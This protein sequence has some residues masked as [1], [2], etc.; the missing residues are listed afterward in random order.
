M[1]GATVQTR[2]TADT[3]DFDTKTKS[4]SSKISSIASSVAKGIGVATAA[5]TAAV[6]KMVSDSVKAFA[7]YEQLIGGTYTLFGTGAAKSLEEYANQ[8][9]KTVDEVKSEYEDLSAAEEIVAVNAW[10]AYKSAGLSANEYLDQVNGFAIGFKTYL[11]GSSKA[12]AELA[13]RVVTA[14]ADIVA[15]TGRSQ[16]SI[17]NAFNGIM[18]GNYMMLDNL[19]MG[20]KPTKEGMQEVIDKVN[21]WNAEQG[22]ATDYQMGNLA[23]MEAALVDYVEMQGLA[24]YAAKEASGTIQ[25]ALK[26]TQASYKNLITTL[27]TGEGLEESINNFFESLSALTTQVLPIIETVLINIANALPGLVDKINEML[28]SLLEGVLPSLIQAVVSLVNGLIKALPSLIKT[29]L[30]PLIEGLLSITTAIIEMLP[31]I[32]IMIAEMLPSLMPQIIDAILSIIPLLIDNL[33]LFLSAGAQL[34]GGLIAGIINSIPIL[35][36]RIGEIVV[37]MIKSFKDIDLK[38]IGKDILKGLWNGLSSMKDWVVDKVKS[39]GKSILKG[40]KGILGIHSPS[41]EFAII[42]RYSILGYTE[43]LDDMQ[44]DV[45]KQVAETFSISPQLSASSGMHF[46]P[47]IINNNYVDIQ[48]DPLGQMVNS[49]KTYSGGAKNDFNYGAGL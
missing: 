30:P 38:Q 48:Q 20:I 17:Q 18:K 36:A 42:G 46:S 45:Q 24:G 35:L 13:D 40:L 49:I 26:M 32:I 6:G 3:K 37:K 21:E 31:D 12:A 5:A 44:S 4:V 22:K 11:G 2:F 9:G 27:A 1:E 33:P 15:A 28:P 10:K 29:L 34:L 16:E 43:A 8:V 25:G 19:Q 7:D 47:N 39:I 41:K 14:E 23:D